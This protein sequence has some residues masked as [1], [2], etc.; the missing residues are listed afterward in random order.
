MRS[1][2]GGA[3][4]RGRGRRGSREV[5]APP[6]RTAHHWYPAIAAVERDTACVEMERLARGERPSRA[7]E[8]DETARA[9]T[10][11]LSMAVSRR[12]A[13]GM[14][15][16]LRTAEELQGLQRVEALANLLEGSATEAAIPVDARGFNGQT[17]MAFAAAAGH[18]DVMQL[19]LRYGADPNLANSRGWTPLMLAC[20][21]NRG[22]AVSVLLGAGVKTDLGKVNREGESALTI[23]L[24]A[25]HVKLCVALVRAGAQLPTMLGPGSAAEARERM[26]DLARKGLHLAASSGATEVVRDCLRVVESQDWDRQ[27]PP[28]V[29]D[30]RSLAE[31][32]GVSGGGTGADEEAMLYAKT[33]ERVEKFLWP[34]H[35]LAKGME[36]RREDL[37]A[38]GEE[39]L[40]EAAGR[41]RRLPCGTIV[42]LAPGHQ[43]AG[44]GALR[45]DETGTVVKVTTDDTRCRVKGPSGRH[46]WYAV[47]ELISWKEKQAAEA[48]A[49][50]GGG[51]LDGQGGAEA[52]TPAQLAAGDGRG[53]TGG[54]SS[55]VWGISQVIHRH[56][57]A[58]AGFQAAEDERRYMQE[59]RR[60]EA[61]RH[62]K[63]L[64][65]KQKQR[66]VHKKGAQA[67]KLLTEAFARGGGKTPE[68]NALQE[69]VAAC[70]I[71]E[72]EVVEW[73]SY[74]RKQ[75]KERK[76]GLRWGSSG[77]EL[78]GQ[79][80]ADDDLL[81]RVDEA[82][83]EVRRKKHVKFKEQQEREETHAQW[84]ALWGGEVPSARERKTLGGDEKVGE[85]PLENPDQ[86]AE[87][88]EAEAAQRA[89]E[90]KMMAQET[91]P[92]QALVARR[93]RQQEIDAAAGEL[94]EDGNAGPKLSG[95]MLGRR[96]AVT[97]VDIGGGGGGGSAS[98][99]DNLT[100][101]LRVARSYEP[102][103]FQT[104]LQFQLGGS[105]SKSSRKLMRTAQKSQAKQAERHGKARWQYAHH[106]LP[107][108]PVDWSVETVCR[109]LR[110]LGLGGA[111][112]KVRGR[113]IDGAQLTYMHVDTFCT[114]ISSAGTAGDVD[115]QMD[116]VF[117]K[118][119]GADGTVK[120][121]S[122]RAITFLQSGFD[123]DR[124]SKHVA[125][126][127]KL[128]KKDSYSSLHLS[129][130]AEDEAALERYIE[131]GHD[132]NGKTALGHSPLILAVGTGQHHLVTMLLKAGAHDPLVP[133]G[134]KLQ[135]AL[136]GGGEER[137]RRGSSSSSSSSDSAS[138][139]SRSGAAG[140]R[141]GHGSTVSTSISSQTDSGDE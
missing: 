139:C 64:W 8:Q 114:L 53:G 27:N 13:E 84:V 6:P 31:A 89:W 117:D 35:R 56:E 127:L 50:N 52:T 110:R 39:M 76:A 21:R 74:S 22:A 115:K 124:M 1:R 37:R 46:C 25:G 5:I 24:A 77:G 130:I 33:G 111:N 70:R 98:S 20:Q 107:S 141:G 120:K 106:D 119:S 38:R 131:Q 97:A 68:G 29:A 9:E 113:H 30:A 17:T 42:L 3:R 69:L 122:T 128:D 67:Q 101:C 87:E 15:R 88:D 108:D 62:Q 104:V 112:H 66:R 19:L 11:R 140:R 60:Q 54:D 71:R 16:L 63:E 48:A 129:I 94:H 41:Q 79:Q 102:D 40:R 80:G 86:D 83:R 96:N 34:G 85:P 55:P 118:W 26:L 43:S 125:A 126:Q 103:Q 58:T 32:S 59:M 109:W 91:T 135:N 7:W 121:A 73:F 36:R 93:K 105:N 137:Q 45:G 49:A 132:V 28:A 82:E 51:E 116:G 78:V 99:L 4:A 44:N 133:V 61:A 65:E 23:A 14:E 18:D 136:H 81:R 92:A 75:A 95:G 12:P 57:S 10:Q 90:E 134:R 47:G 138:S 123:E 100:K 2:E 72:A